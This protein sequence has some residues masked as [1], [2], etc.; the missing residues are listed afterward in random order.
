MT[1]MADRLSRLT[2]DQRA[3]LLAKLQQAREAQIRDAQS[4][5]RRI[6][7][8]PRERNNVALSFTQERL[9]FLEQF[10]PG[11]PF[12]NMS[13]VAR[14]PVRVDPGLF[15]QCLDDVVQ[16]HDILRMSC[17]SWRTWTRP[18]G[19]GSSA[20]M[21]ARRSTWPPLPCCGSPSRRRGRTNA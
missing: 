17:A 6:G 10:A 8:A 4:Q 15:G 18:S 7:P 16:R 3:L 14:V 19:T 11:T 1:D 12:N 5:G 13:G 20:R 9:W 21:R 2:E